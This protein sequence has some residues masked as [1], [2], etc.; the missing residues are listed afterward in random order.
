M[1]AIQADIESGKA[2]EGKHGANR[3]GG[4]ARQVGKEGKR[5]QV[6]SHHEEGHDLGGED[7]RT[8]VG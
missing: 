7:L 4:K 3:T 6:W 5:G 2:F 1:T 8:E